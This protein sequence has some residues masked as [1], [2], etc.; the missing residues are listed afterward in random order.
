MHMSQSPEPA[1]I[2]LRPVTSEDNDFLMEV[3]GST[4]AEEMA[5]VPWTAKYEGE[6]LLLRVLFDFRD[7]GQLQFHHGVF[8]SLNM[9]ISTSMPGKLCVR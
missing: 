8:V 2:R 7:F 1:N 4:R 5:L 6:L 3:Y 9:E